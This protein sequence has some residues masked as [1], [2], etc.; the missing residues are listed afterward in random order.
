MQHTAAPLGDQDVAWVTDQFQQKA[1]NCSEYAAC[2]GASWAMV[3]DLPGSS[4]AAEQASFCTAAALLAVPLR[5]AEAA[6]QKQH[7]WSSLHSRPT[8]N[9]TAQGGSKL[10][11]QGCS[12][13]QQQHDEQQST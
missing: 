13:A 5:T 10:L 9:R 11:E 6:Q 12:L 4:D 7:M 8:A 1:D 3:A 2:R